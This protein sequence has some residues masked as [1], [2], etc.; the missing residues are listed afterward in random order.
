MA[1]GIITLEFE[2]SVDIIAETKKIASSMRSYSTN[3]KQWKVDLLELPFLLDHL[4]WLGLSTAR[5]T[6]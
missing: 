4:S 2:Y 3:T 1:C 5:S 6:R